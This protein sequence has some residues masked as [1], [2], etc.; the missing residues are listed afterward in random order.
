MTDYKSWDKFDVEKAEVEV[1]ERVA[2]DEIQAARRKIAAAAIDQSSSIVETARKTA[3][4]L[5]SKVVTVAS[6]T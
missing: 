3:D 2:V 5:R 6:V 1:D 4:A